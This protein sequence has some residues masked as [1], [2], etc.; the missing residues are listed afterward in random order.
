MKKV[1][2]RDFRKPE[3]LDANPDDYEFDAD[4]NPVR[5]DRWE[6]GIRAIV[7]ILGWSRRSF[8]VDA[9]VEEVEHRLRPIA[10]PPQV[11]DAMMSL[12]VQSIVTPE[13]GK[14]YKVLRD[15]LL[16]MEKEDA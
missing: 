5:K 4:G 3:F 14:D 13:I 16:P 8:T 15:Y 6:R 9:V 10:I 7:G 12:S 2:E 1:T 11:V